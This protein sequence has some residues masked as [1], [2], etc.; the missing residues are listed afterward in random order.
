MAAE[1]LVVEAVSGEWLPRYHTRLCK[2]TPRADHL[3]PPFLPVADDVST[4]VSPLAH[5]TRTSSGLNSPPPRLLP[6]DVAAGAGPSSSAASSAPTDLL[7]LVQSLAP[8]LALVGSTS[9][10]DL[11]QIQR[12]LA[13]SMA[14][15]TQEMQDRLLR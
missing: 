12:L 7:A 11:V 5:R 2:M 15:V 3:F 9:N 13:A 14:S 8:E 4:H 10:A 1:T 6:K